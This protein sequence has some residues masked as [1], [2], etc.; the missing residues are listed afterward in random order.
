[1]YRNNK[2][3]RFTAIAWIKCVWFSI[4]FNFITELP[5]HSLLYTLHLS[6]S[7]TKVYF[8]PDTLAS[9]AFI[10]N[11]NWRRKK[12]NKKNYEKYSLNSNE[13]TEVF[14]QLQ[15]SSCIPRRV[16]SAARMHFV[17]YSPT[18]SA[19]LP[20]CC[21]LPLHSHVH[22]LMPG[23]LCL[24]GW[25]PVD[26]A[27]ICRTQQLLVCEYSGMPQPALRHRRIL[28]APTDNSYYN[29]K[30]ISEWVSA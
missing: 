6:T 20:L 11:K 9:K 26:S 29:N 8:E 18:T 16:S 15:R 30:R 7:S 27:Y 19:P 10:S 17:F 12:N 13:I 2:K 22:K 28:F 4:N 25:R 14:S 24:V 21:V 3:H 1:M 5:T 23:V